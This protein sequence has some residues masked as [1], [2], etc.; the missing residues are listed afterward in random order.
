VRVGVGMFEALERGGA[1]WQAPSSSLL[2]GCVH[3]ISCVGVQAGRHPF[4]PC[5][6]RRAMCAWS[7]CLRTDPGA[8][9]SCLFGPGREDWQQLH[10]EGKRVSAWSCMHFFVGRLFKSH[11][12]GAANQSLVCTALRS[13]GK[14]GRRDMLNCQA[15][16][17][18]LCCC[19]VLLLHAGFGPGCAASAQCRLCLLCPAA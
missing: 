2:L 3:M 6:P 8:S 11:Q 1:G 5:C 19:C 18:L 10:V 7:S 14:G 12:Q 16:Y 13:G 17:F 9:C 15:C 4:L